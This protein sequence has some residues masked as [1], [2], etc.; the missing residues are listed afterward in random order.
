MAS[1]IIGKNPLNF[2]DRDVIT[3][4]DGLTIATFLKK[5]NIVFIH[6]TIC[7]ANGVDD[8]AILLK[9]EQQD[10][11]LKA[12]DVIMFIPQLMGG[13]GSNPLK[14]VIGLA[15]MTFSGGI[16][17]A[18]AGSFLGGAITSGMIARF[19]AAVI[20]S[21]FSQPKPPSASA[22]DIKEA[23]PTYSL[24]A[25][26]NI[27][28]LGSAIPKV[29]G[30][31]VVFPPF[32]AAPWVEYVGNEQ[33]L[34]Q[35]FVIGHGKYATETPRLEDSP[36]TS[37]TKV[38]WAFLEYDDL[39]QMTV[40]NNGNGI[41]NLSWLNA[42]HHQ[43]ITSAEVSGQ[44]LLGSNEVDYGYVGPF[45]V[46][47]AGTT[48]SAIAIDLIAPRGLYYAEDNGAMSP[49]TVTWQVEAQTINDDGEATG[50]WTAITTSQA[51]TGSSTAS[52]DIPYPVDGVDAPQMTVVI[53]TGVKGTSAVSFVQTLESAMLVSYYVSNSGGND[54]IT[55]VVQPAFNWAGDSSIWGGHVEFGFNYSYVSSSASPSKAAAT[56][57]VQQWSYSVGVAPARYQVR[58]KRIDA[59]DTNSRAGH[60]LRWAGLRGITTKAPDYHGLTLLYTRFK[61]TDQLSQQ[62]SRKVNCVVTSILYT[63]FGNIATSNPAWVMLDVMRSYYG[64]RL[65]ERQYDLD[66]LMQLAITLANHDDQFNYVSDS[67]S[68]VWDALKLVGQTCRV[69]PSIA[70]GKVYFVRDQPR[71]YP[72]CLF[73]PA[74][75]RKGSFKIER[76]MPGERTAGWLE[77]EFF[78][79]K[80]WDWR[81]VLV[82]TQ[83]Q[84][85]T[86]LPAQM[87]FEG[88]TDE[89]QVKRE[90]AY[91]MAC[92]TKRRQ[93]VTFETEMDGFIPTFGDLITVSHDLPN[94]G[95]QAYITAVSGNK[96]T[97]NVLL[98][99]QGIG[100]VVC[101]R[102]KSGKPS[103]P[104][105]VTRTGADNV[106][107]LASA[108]PFSPSLY[109]VDAEPTSIVFGVSEEWAKPCIVLGV[110]PRG[111]EHVEIS[112]VVDND[113]V[114]DAGIGWQPGLAGG[115]G[116]VYVVPNGVYQLKVFVLPAQEGGDGEHVLWDAI[117]EVCTYSIIPAVPTAG[118]T[119]FGNVATDPWAIESFPIPNHVPQQSALSVVNVVQGQVIPYQL[120]VGG[121]GVTSA[122]DI[123][124]CG[125]IPITSG[126]DGLSGRIIVVP[127]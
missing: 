40:K 64:G 87:R 100:H 51:Y 68:T 49:K 20:L 9:A 73:S 18:F 5:Q 39:G 25:Q 35:I 4:P 30:R 38:D 75:M 19:G 127:V 121:S 16:A 120:G 117:N 90:A 31:H 21:A 115:V 89:A 106:F 57:E 8:D 33:Y 24:Q 95:Q 28:G 79:R 82:G 105:A 98:D 71:A 91:L 36:I 84:D 93:F 10:Y 62:A 34:T 3:A 70:G 56:N 109:G 116:A 96:I 119:S 123:V 43:V 94:W 14:V 124:H 88:I 118:I 1:I 50:S 83:P 7:Y 80:T 74:N 122:G 77:A 52:I 13:G 112:A 44:E 113:A 97:T 86:A 54:K 72:I 125:H 2:N 42:A 67:R 101:L 15:L 78:D 6:P 102:D 27:A 48:I 65:S 46:N 108:V 66:G 26:G 111:M 22:N 85:P 81:K 103:N 55:A 63:P 76:I 41:G 37:F 17:G 99:W 104:I 53:D 47:K 45:V 29:Y 11:R 32:I 61:A 59:K 69:M 58:A 23:S 107:T 114:Y 60:E 126:K 92:N 12:T 110:R